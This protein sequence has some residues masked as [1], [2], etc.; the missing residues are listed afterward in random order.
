MVF[1]LGN[2]ELKASMAQWLVATGDSVWRDL[3][4]WQLITSPL[5][6]VQFISLIF[7][8]FMLWMF[9]PTLERWWGTKRFVIF[10]LI[11]IRTCSRKR[12]DEGEVA[13]YRMLDDD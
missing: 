10:A 13:K 8:G 2:D 9:L 12:K 4:V 5:L 7:Q 6:E 3:K 1:L 11:V